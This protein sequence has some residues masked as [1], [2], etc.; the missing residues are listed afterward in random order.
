MKIVYF[1][2]WG[3]TN[4]NYAF[5][6]LNK[7]EQCVSSFSLLAVLVFLPTGVVLENGL[8][9]VRNYRGKFNH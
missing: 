2:C 9:S 7:T 6:Y 3:K 8:D 5:V 4:T 1:Y